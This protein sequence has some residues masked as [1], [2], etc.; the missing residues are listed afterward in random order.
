MA[1]PPRPR[2]RAVRQSIGAVPIQ[3]RRAGHTRDARRA[4]SLGGRAPSAEAA[5]LRRSWT[6]ALVGYHVADP[7]QPPDDRE[8]EQALRL[9]RQFHGYRSTSLR[10][11]RGVRA[12]PSVLVH[13]GQLRAV[14]YSSDRGQR[15][16]PQLYIHWMESQPQLVTNPEGTQLYLVGGRY[17]VTR[18]GIEG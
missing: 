8:I 13:V 18:R 4:E 3:C 14:V 6:G 7:E 1:G 17:R 16:R 10:L 11:S 9:F 5:A 12:T 2:A 15:G